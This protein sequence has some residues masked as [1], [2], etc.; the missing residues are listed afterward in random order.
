MPTWKESWT[1]WQ[2]PWAWDSCKALHAQDQA[3]RDAGEE[4]TGSE[5]GCICWEHAV[6]GFKLWA[7]GRCLSCHIWSPAWP[8]LLSLF[9]LTIAGFSRPLYS[10][11]WPSRLLLNCQGLRLLNQYLTPSLFRK[12][13]AR[14]ITVTNPTCFHLNPRRFITLNGNDICSSGRSM[15]IQWN[16]MGSASKPLRSV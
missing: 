2:W 9:L 7:V 13:R 8:F 16:Q 11:G 3:G 10:M 1:L 5:A 6:K 4:V 15:H 12:T 14:H